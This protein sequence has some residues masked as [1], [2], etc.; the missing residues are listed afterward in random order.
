MQAGGRAGR[1]AGR[2]AGL[3]VRPAVY[4]GG[5]NPAG[6]GKRWGSHSPNWGPTTAGSARPCRRRPCRPA[7][8]S[9]PLERGQPAAV[10]GGAELVRSGRLYAVDDGGLR[11]EEPRGSPRPPVTASGLGCS[12]TL[13]QN[14]PGNSF[15]V[16]FV[17]SLSQRKII[18][19][20]K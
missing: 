9:G 1:Q 2:R 20:I 6:T 13:L 8:S 14:I 18:I 19:I 7:G 4:L 15:A 17:L 16:K 11:G 12:L 5:W 3:R 10:A